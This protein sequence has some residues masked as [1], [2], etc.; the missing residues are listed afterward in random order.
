[1]ATS[2][3]RQYKNQMSKAEWEVPVLQVGDVAVVLYSNDP[4]SENAN[5]IDIDCGDTHVASI[6]RTGAYVLAN[7]MRFH[8]NGHGTYHNQKMI[9]SKRHAIHLSPE[10]DLPKVS[11]RYVTKPCDY[12]GH[13]S[14]QAQ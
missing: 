14:L 10:G 3:N 2:T 7:G 11:G 13:Y 12:E 5:F 1:M 6:A 9:V 8:K 4:T